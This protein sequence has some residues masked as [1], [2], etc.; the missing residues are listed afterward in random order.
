VLS[1]ARLL[2]T[3]TGGEAG[4]VGSVGLL[5]LAGRENQF[6]VDLPGRGRGIEDDFLSEQ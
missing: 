5:V 4:A 6:G 3:A 2:E 1:R